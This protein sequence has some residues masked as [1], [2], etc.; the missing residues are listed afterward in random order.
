MTAPTQTSSWRFPLLALALVLP[1]AAWTWSYWSL[2]P[3]LQRTWASDPQSSHGYIV[4]LFALLLLWLRRDL[5]R[6]GEISPSWWGLP[7]LAAGVILRLVGARTYYVW[8]DQLSLV[9]CLAGLCWMVGGKTAWRWAWP[10]IAFLLFMI[11]L[12]FSLATALAAPLQR[13]ATVCSTFV[14]VTLGLPAIAEGNVIL[15]HDAQIGVVEACSGL[16]MLVVFFALSTALVL[17]V[18]RPVTDKIVLVLS[19]IPIA[20][21]ANLVRITATGVLHEFASSDLANTFFHDVA[22][23]F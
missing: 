18:K 10:A 17:L 7:F 13:L 19:A 15:L 16:R 22:G 5:L 6:Q 4:P 8:L 12:P 20:L 11:P 9:P 2:F 3:D 14:M 1:L 23:W 21:L